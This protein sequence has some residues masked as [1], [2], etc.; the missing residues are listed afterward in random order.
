MLLRQLPE[1]PVA[2]DWEVWSERLS[3]CVDF[4]LLNVPAWGLLSSYSELSDSPI[5]HWKNRHFRELWNFHQLLT[6]AWLQW[7]HLRFPAA[8]VC[9]FYSFLD[10]FQLKLENGILW[11]ILEILIIEVKPWILQT[12][13]AKNIVS[14]VIR[15]VFRH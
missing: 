6:L 11:G 8:L 2:N 1:F 5:F 14:E 4:N 12:K 10:P 13:I 7:A 15:K 9:H 3:L